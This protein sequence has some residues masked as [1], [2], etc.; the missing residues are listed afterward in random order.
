VLS[1]QYAKYFTLDIRDE[2]K[3]QTESAKLLNMDAEE[4]V[5]MF[6]A[7]QQRAAHATLCFKSAKIKAKKNKTMQFVNGM[8]QEDRER[9]LK[10]MVNAGARR[11]TTNR[12]RQRV[13]LAEISNQQRD[14]RQKKEDKERRKI[15]KVLRATPIDDLKDKVEAE[16]LED[17][18][19]IISGRA[20]RR[21][22]LH[23]WFDKDTKTYDA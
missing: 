22:L 11:R 6:S 4:I 9:L 10:W 20:V 23:W 15:K 19:E 7:A 5:G 8:S 17:V 16:F 12:E 2:L 18:V 21:Y 14:K 3:K 1:R 13:T